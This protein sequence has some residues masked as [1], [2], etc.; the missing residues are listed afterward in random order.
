M[1]KQ[2]N[3]DLAA[4]LEDAQQGRDDG[5][6]LIVRAGS[7]Y[8]KVTAFNAGKYAAALRKIRA[9]RQRGELRSYPKFTPGMSTA[10]YVA[11]FAKMNTQEAAIKADRMP[12]YVLPFGRL[13]TAPCAL[14]EN[15]A[16]D[17][18]VIEEIDAD[19]TQSVAAPEVQSAP[20]AAVDSLYNPG[21]PDP[22]NSAALPELDGFRPGDVVDVHGRTIG[23]STIELVFLRKL[24]GFDA[25]PLARIVGA[26]GKRLDVQLFQLT[27]V[28]APA[29]PAEVQA[30]HVAA[31]P[32]VSPPCGDIAPA[33]QDVAESKAAAPVEIEAAEGAA[34]PAG[35]EQA[36]AEDYTITIKPLST[37]GKPY[38]I[39]RC[40]S[41]DG[42]KTRAARLASSIAR[43][44]YSHRQ[45]GYVMST[46]AAARFEALYAE[47]A[48]ACAITGNVYNPSAVNDVI[49]QASSVAESG[50]PVADTT[51]SGIAPASPEYVALRS[52]AREARRA[53]LAAIDTARVSSAQA[54]RELTADDS[55][56][57]YLIP[58]DGAAA[59]AEPAPM[60]APEPANAPASPEFA[61][62]KSQ[63][64][65]LKEQ[66]QQS[67]QITPAISPS[68]FSD[69]RTGSPVVVP[70]KATADAMAR[71]RQLS[72]KV[73]VR[74]AT[75]EEMADERN[76]FTGYNA[77]EGRRIGYVLEMLQPQRKERSGH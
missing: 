65:K 55:D 10:E 62:I 61:M 1:T 53:A 23:R 41:S 34:A 63:C 4:A 19:D 45:G 72:G 44:R 51:C 68:L 21:T 64:K 40:P 33:A 22:K 8:M 31:S 48:D 17:F 5:V 15:G 2:L 59:P 46:A 35:P 12:A 43:D 11:K 38:A 7:A 56:Y 60:T 9:P 73:A 75:P 70:N 36:A 47:G 58:S 32:E 54:L 13:N 26:S 24:A 74:K 16:R 66:V 69:Q 6:M 25:E 71:S 67:H 18:D 14:Y 42:Y 52:A 3:L 77:G 30:P 39:V 50:A 37:R 76:A 57:S 20:A 27:R 49:E 28:E 29:A